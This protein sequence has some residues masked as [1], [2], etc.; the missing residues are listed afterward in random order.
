M[1]LWE[2]HS[3]LIIGDFFYRNYATIMAMPWTML[4]KQMEPSRKC[5]V[6]VELRSV[7]NKCFDQ[8]WSLSKSRLLREFWTYWTCIQALLL[9]DPS[10]IKWKTLFLSNVDYTFSYSM[11]EMHAHYVVCEKYTSR[12]VI[13]PHFFSKD[14]WLRF[15]SYSLDLFSPDTICMSYKYIK[16]PQIHFYINIHEYWI[17][18]LSIFTWVLF[19]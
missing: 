14:V 19:V 4:C 17:S 11:F 7:A 18:L 1:G 8:T 12:V 13:W 2:L 9:A 3:T 5:H 6:I 16:I 10:M 15:L